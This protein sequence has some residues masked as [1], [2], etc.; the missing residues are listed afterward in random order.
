[1]ERSPEFLQRG[2]L[3]TLEFARGL[4]PKTSPPRSPAASPARPIGNGP[5]DCLPAVLFLDADGLLHPANVGFPGQLRQFRQGC[6]ELV[7]RIVAETACAVVLSTSGFNNDVFCALSEKLAEYGIPFVSRIAHPEYGSVPSI[8]QARRATDILA[9][10]QK[11]RP[12]TWVALDDC[13]VP[14]GNFGTFRSSSSGSF[15]FQSFV[16]KRFVQMRPR[17]GLQRDTADA[18]IS[19]FRA[20]DGENAALEP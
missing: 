14:K 19:A 3:S 13:P 9:W 15:R 10:V 7:Q 11:H 20:Q 5:V 18:V 4:R 17:S 2:S 16:P 12:R 8:A 6:F 1:M